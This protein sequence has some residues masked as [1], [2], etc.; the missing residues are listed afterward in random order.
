MKTL[1]EEKR[2]AIEEL[3]RRYRVRQLELFGSAVGDRFDP[4]TSDLDFLVE[5]EGLPPAEHSRCYFGLLFALTD[6]FGRDVDLVET[7]AI[8]NPYFL[9]AIANDR[10]LLYAA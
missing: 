3:C 8:R 6:L 4:Q 1:I 9:R 10:M 2:G 7:G 5:F